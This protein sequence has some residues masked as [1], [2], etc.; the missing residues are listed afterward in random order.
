[1]LARYLD[2]REIT[3]K[4]INEF[5]IDMLTRDKRRSGRSTPGKGKLSV[6]TV[7]T[8]L[9]TVRHFCKWMYANQYLDN[10]IASSIKVPKMPEPQP[11]AIKPD[12]MTAL[13]SAAMDYGT[14]AQRARNVAILYWLR[15]TGGRVGGLLNAT[16]ENLDLVEGIVET[17][18]K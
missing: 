10:D 3:T 12:D 7:R 13:L 9:I 11:K 5:R 18:E 17:R 2:D 4:A 1:M 14:D 15:D 16:M 8:V 6:F